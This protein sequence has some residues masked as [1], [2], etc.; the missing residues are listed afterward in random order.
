MK[1][2]R[3]SLH[4]SLDIV[5]SGIFHDSRVYE[6]QGDKALG[7]HD[8]SKVVFH[9]PL[10]NAPSI[11]FFEEGG[12]RYGNPNAPYGPL[13]EVD[14]PSVGRDLD[15]RVR[16]AYVSKDEGQ[17]ISSDEAADFVLAV[18]TVAEFFFRDTECIA[19]Y[20]M[21]YAM[22]PFLVTGEELEGQ[23]LSTAILR[24]NGEEVATATRS[25]ADATPLF[26]AASR[27]RSIH[28]G[29]VLAAPAFDFGPLDQT[30]LGR[31]LQPSD[32]VQVQ[33]APLSPLTLNII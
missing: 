17:S 7:I 29:D 30:S 9:A 22:G 4:E 18:T 24:V 19:G 31:F 14:I 26:V 28:T 1:L 32:Q 8:L 3:F 5:R 11:R 2:C 15:T 21:P 16:L 33:I 25:T 27:P 23:P 6:T 13:G 20:D 12:Y 10:G